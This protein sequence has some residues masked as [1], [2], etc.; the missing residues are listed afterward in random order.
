MP[1]TRQTSRTREALIIG[2]RYVLPIGLVLI[3]F[4]ML[5]VVDGSLKWDG[6]AMCVGAGLSVALMNVL[7]RYGAKGDH[8]RDDEERARE[9]MAE[10]GHWPDEPPPTRRPGGAG[11]ARRTAPHA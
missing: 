3:G 5:F 1:S 10:H 9:F 7:F 4:A 11:G 8:E 6:F 2:M